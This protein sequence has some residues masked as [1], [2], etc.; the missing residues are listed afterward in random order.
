M[1]VAGQHAEWAR[2]LAGASGPVDALA[3]CRRVGMRVVPLPLPGL[4]CAI[5]GDG[6]TIINSALSS[7]RRAHIALHELGHHMIHGPQGG[8]R[9]WR[10]RDWVMASKVERQAED[11]AYFVH[12]PADEL[13][14]LLWDETPIREIGARYD[15]SEAWVMTRIELACAA[16]E[17][18][19][20]R[21]RAA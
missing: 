11:F 17:L 8:Y 4:I 15:R 2:L 18:A 21:T 13:Q 20:W 7:R 12:L 16:G 3:L 5:Y 14:T 19:E 6:I 9:F 1:W 10:E